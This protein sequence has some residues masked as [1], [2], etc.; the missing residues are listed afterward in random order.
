MLWGGASRLGFAFGLAGLVLAG[1]KPAAQP[2]ASSAAPPPLAALP[3]STS[4]APAIAPAPTADALPMAPRARTGRIADPRDRYAFADRAYAMNAGFGDAPPDYTFDYGD[5]ERPWVWRGDDDS[6]RVAEPLPDGGDRYYYYDAGADTPYL[7]RDSDYSYGYD[8]G[9]LVVIYDRQGRALPPDELDRRADLAGRFLDRARAI[10]RTSLSQQR[11]AV[12]QAN[13][14]ARRDAIAAERQQWADRQS[15]DQDWRAYH[16]AHAQ[17]DQAHWAAERYRREAE[18]ARFAQTVE[19]RPRAQQD[20]QAAQ[21][22]QAPAASPGQPPPQPH[23]GGLSAGPPKPQPALAPP[24]PPPSSVPSVQAGQERTHGSDHGHA[25]GSPLAAH[26]VSSQPAPTPN[27]ASRVEPPRQAPDVSHPALAP[28]SRAAA[29][30][31]SP[32]NTPP[33]LA[34]RAEAPAARPAQV[35]ATAAPPR[36]PIEPRAPVGAPGQAPQRTGHLAELA[37]R[38]PPVAAPIQGEVKPPPGDKPQR[39]HRRG[40]ESDHPPGEQP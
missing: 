12:A 37:A 40:P 4:G 8:N 13:W 22:A 29:E 30:R 2:A 3:L 5:G 33:D 6:M 23:D 9:V 39:P 27:V 17:Q 28:P 24:A 7:V 16:D 21:K 25:P 1:C 19:D 36:P 26:A 31:Q 10:H 38:K 35:D 34:R 15:A 14:V 20:W 32:V 11:Q 18:A